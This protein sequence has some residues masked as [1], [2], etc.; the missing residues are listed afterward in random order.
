MRDLYIGFVYLSFFVIGAT[1]PFVLTLGYLWVDT[2]FPQAVSDYV[3]LIPASMTVA[4]A[5]IVAYLFADRRAPP[6]FTTHTAITL[7]YGL[8][9]TATLLWAVVPES[10]AVKWDWAFK[11]VMFSAFITLVIRSRVQIEAFLQVF[12]FGVCIHI[13]PLGIKSLISGSAYGRQLGIIR[14][15]S[16]LAESSTLATASIA[17][18]PIILFLRTHSILIPK[19]KYRD[20][21]YFA[22][23]GIAVMCAI[24]TYARTAMVGFVVVGV[25]MW[26]QSRRKVVF[27]L[28]IVASVIVFGAL[29]SS[30]W[31]ERI[32]SSTNFEQEDSA[33]GR[34]LVW[35]W[36]LGFVAENPLGGGF[37]SYEIDRIEFPAVN[38]QPGL[39]VR[40]KAFHNMY[41][42][43][44]GEHG[45]PGLAMFLTVLTISLVYLFRVNWR[46]RGQPHLLWLSDLARALMTALL[47]VMACGCFIGIG[48]QAFVWYFIALPVC[49]YEYLH[50]VEKL[51]KAS[52]LT[53]VPGKMVRGGML[54]TAG[55]AR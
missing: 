23:V 4:I 24:G 43:V 2:F 46:T 19:S 37:N 10:A 9:I 50:R 17:L 1:T 41:F 36:T 25:F 38:G 34:L 16:L 30:A 20:I 12:L 51:E 31:E 49:V 53:A 18:I 6:R 42:E 27:G 13:L 8:W 5:A 47:T 45:I 44:L 32:A 54:P 14:G 35:Q 55:M 21:G 26:L 22:L 7:S 48:F 11:T 3:A 52:A 15:N 39:V 40:S 29:T 33:L 28:A